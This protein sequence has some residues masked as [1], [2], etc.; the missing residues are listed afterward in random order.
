MF[1]TIKYKWQSFLS[2]PV[3]IFLLFWCWEADRI[4]LYSHGCSSHVDQPGLKDTEVFQG[5]LPTRPPVLL[6]VLCDFSITTTIP[7][8]FVILLTL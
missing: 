7:Q 3:L 6:F 8:V 2:D 1:F 4:S 5:W